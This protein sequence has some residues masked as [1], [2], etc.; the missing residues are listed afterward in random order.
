G[1]DYVFEPASMLKILYATYCIDSCAAGTDSLA[2]S[3]YVANRCNPNACPDTVAPC[4]S[5]FDT[6]DTA[7]ALML[8]NSDNN[9]TK[10][11]HDR[12][13]RPTL[14]NSAAFLGMS[15]TH[16]NH[17]IG[18]GL[19]ANQLTLRDAGHL[20]EL[21]ANNSLFSQAWEDTLH[22]HMLNNDGTIGSFSSYIS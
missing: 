20:Y 7:L 22:Q 13:G 21:I 2:N 8:M 19:P 14:N 11:I 4:N 9:R 6:L 12:Y 3:I 5:G 1:A 15:S 18:C 10:S 16:I 17:D